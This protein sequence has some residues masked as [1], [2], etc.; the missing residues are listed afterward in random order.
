MQL[1]TDAN[2]DMLIVDEVSKPEV[3]EEK[4]GRAKKG[5]VKWAEIKEVDENAADDEDGKQKI[6]TSEMVI[7]VDELFVERFPDNELYKVFMLLF[8]C[9]VVINMDHGTLPACVEQV[10]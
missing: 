3:V 8:A 5:H 9:N 4:T 6:S 2:D 10:K 7:K 1:T